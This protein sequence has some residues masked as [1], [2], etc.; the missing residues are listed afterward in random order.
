MLYT[1]RNILVLTAAIGALFLILLWSDNGDSTSTQPA[2]AN[3]STNLLNQ[4]KAPKVPALSKVGEGQ[5]DS[6]GKAPIFPVENKENKTSKKRSQEE[7][8]FIAAKTRLMEVEERVYAANPYLKQIE[9]YRGMARAWA[10]ENE[11]VRFRREYFRMVEH[12][13]NEEKILKASARI[14]HLLI[15]LI[16]ENLESSDDGVRALFDA[17]AWYIVK[18]F[19][20]HPEE[21]GEMNVQSAPTLDD[22]LNSI[23]RLKADKLREIETIRS[24]LGIPHQVVAGT[25]AWETGHLLTHLSD[26]YIATHVPAE[27]EDARNDYSLAKR[28]WDNYRHQMHRSAS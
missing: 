11:Y 21:V 25:L 23:R 4:I 5:K 17:T 26:V 28:Q 9:N 10:D 24:E 6:A 16:I 14:S 12:T 20:P 22:V 15:P 2:Q 18:Q 1:R 13:L 3:L 27:L 8:N 7:L 19:S